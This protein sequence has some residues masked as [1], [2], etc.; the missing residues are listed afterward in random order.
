M[1]HLEPTQ[2]GLSGLMLHEDADSNARDRLN[3]RTS[4]SQRRMHYIPR[5]LLTHRRATSNKPGGTAEHAL[6]N[7]VPI[8]WR[9]AGYQLKGS[10]L[11]SL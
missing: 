9:T 5:A 2:Q 10:Q 8:S 6:K 11:S 4:L 7:L 1:Q 3:A